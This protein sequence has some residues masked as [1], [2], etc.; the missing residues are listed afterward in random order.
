MVEYNSTTPTGKCIFCEIAR[1]NMKPMWE[2]IIY[3]DEKYMAWLS[4]FPNTLWAIVVIPKNHFASDVLEM[5]D[6]ELSEFVL[7]SKKISKILINYFADVGRVWL[8][9]EWTWID[10]AHIKLF[11]MHG[12]EHMKRWEWIQYHSKNH[13]FIEKY[14]WY[15]ASNDWPKADF[16]ELKK[17]ANEIKKVIKQ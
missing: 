7:I 11:P 15:F 9:M 17:L 5:P 8:A 10:H 3:E 14:E 16:E 1:W 12:T 2:S 13:E 6:D 4:P